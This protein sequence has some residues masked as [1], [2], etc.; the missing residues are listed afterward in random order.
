MTYE[1]RKSAVSLF[2]TLFASILYYWL[3]ARYFGERMADPNPDLRFWGGFILGYL[4]AAVII[5]VIVQIVYII[6]EA[7]ITRREP[8]EL[9][10]ELGRLIELKS[11]QTFNYVF[12]A[13]FFLTMLGLV[14]GMA[15]TT[16]FLCFYLSMVAAGC[17]L[18]I[19][20]LWFYRRGVSLA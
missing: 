2:I 8:S 14:L 5:K 18:D 10:D 12:F 15:A 11:I 4:P 6:L 19:A 16:M 9:T 20:Q 13:G 1:E 3:V 17:S 7:A